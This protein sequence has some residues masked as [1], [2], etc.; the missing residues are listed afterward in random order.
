MPGIKEC[1][2]L[3]VGQAGCSV[4]H[5]TWELFT[6]EH[7]ILPDGTRGP[8][9]S[10]FDPTDDEYTSF[11]HATTGGQYVPRAVFV[12]TEPSVI[13]EL[14]AG[15]MRKLFHPDSML[16]FKQ[17]AKSN[18]FEGRT[19]ASAFKIQE[20]VVDR[21]RLAAELCNN[22][23]GFFAFHSF[24]GGT[25]SG[26]GVEVLHDLRDQ[27]DKK[28][29]MQPAILPS[30]N[31]SN[32]I[33][34]PYNCMF[35]MHYT[36]DVVDL[37]YML[38]NEAAY[39][40]CK[41]ALQIK[42]PHFSHVN[43][44]IAQ[45]V[46]GA[47]GPLRYETE[48]NATLQEQ[49]TSLVPQQPYRYAMLSLAPLRH[50]ERGVHEQFKTPEIVNELFE[51]K[52]F[53]CDCSGKNGGNL[54]NNRYLAA[55]LLLRGEGSDDVGTDRMDRTAASS[56][57]KTRKGATAA[58]NRADF[59]PVSVNAVLSALHNLRNPPANR[60]STR[61]VKFLPW[62]EGSGFKVGVVRARPIIPE[63]FTVARSKRQGMLIGNNTAVR[64]IFLRQYTR[65]LKLFYY[66]AYIWQ[67]IEANGE[68]DAFEEAKES[69]REI[70]DKYEELLV[71]SSEAE[72]QR[73]QQ[74]GTGARA[75]LYGQT[76]RG[77]V[78]EGAS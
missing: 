42:E 75:R 17:D 28:C 71:L 46:S 61:C 21:I 72:T 47:T 10:E 62:M 44:L 43:R 52:N 45:C 77:S 27:F 20:V 3:H 24:G 69:V 15:N 34:E 57:E 73:L 23:Q 30:V 55:V 14:R 78:R 70:L 59:K 9:C 25:G 66:K 35:T 64:Q 26:V 11:F 36:R 7:G 40:I 19:I 29:I 31:Y 22:L 8:D 56:K 67:F 65:F 39:R 5:R 18:F 54:K 53:L 32:S 41:D 38:D 58:D 16:S 60:S 4:G 50:E 2:C 13:N 12:D 48:I 49:V 51:E 63:G 74:G 68:P 33:V 6:Q 76:E 1:I 37:T